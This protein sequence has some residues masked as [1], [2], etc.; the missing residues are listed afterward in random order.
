M[1]AG[2]GNDVTLTAGPRGGLVQ[3]PTLSQWSLLLL[4]ML[5]FAVGAIQERRR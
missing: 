1:W 5:L 3:T 4:A 2:T